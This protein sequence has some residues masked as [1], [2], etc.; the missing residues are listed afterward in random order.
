MVWQLLTWPLDSLIWIAEQIDERASA[1][2]DRTEN[3]QKKLTTLQLRFD[4]GEISEADFVE[5]EQEILEALEAEWQEAK[6][7]EQEQEME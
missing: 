1:E 6:K 5:Q 4:L 3:L 7:K 2:L